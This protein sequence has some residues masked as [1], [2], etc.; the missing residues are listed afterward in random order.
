MINPM[1]ISACVIKIIPA[2]ILW[3]AILFFS[4]LLAHNAVLYFTHGGDYGI[5]PEKIE[6]RK[7]WLWIVCFYIHLPAG[8]LCLMLPWLAFLRRVTPKI[9]GIHRGVGRLFITVTLWIVCPTGIYL[10]IYAKG[11]LITQTGFVLQGLLLAYYTRVAYL[12]A[13]RGMIGKHVE[14]MI[15]AY[16][17]AV[18]VLT[19][20]IFH[21]LFFVLNLPYSTN[22]ALSQWLGLAFNLL[23]AEMI[24]AFSRRNVSLKIQS[25]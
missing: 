6:A 8:I 25:I 24:I 11:G 7:D 23:M 5:L 18:V 3:I 9:N 2:S 13:I 19:F 14:N 10:A 21:I 1:K 4:S 12:F 16:S 22:Y 17:V 15:R 20:R